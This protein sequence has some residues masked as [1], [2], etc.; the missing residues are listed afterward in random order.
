MPI[1]GVEQPE[2]I[3]IDDLAKKLSSIRYMR[4]S[5]IDGK[6]QFAV[7]GDIVD[8]FPYGA[9]NPIRI[10]FFDNEIDSVRIFDILSQRTIEKTEYGTCSGKRQWP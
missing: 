10:E 1:P 9:E 7:R 8:I 6:G 3:E 5:E 2:I 4:L